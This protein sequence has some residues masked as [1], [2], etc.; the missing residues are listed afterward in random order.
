MTSELI[1]MN[2]NV[3]RILLIQDRIVNKLRCGDGS[4][5]VTDAV[6]SVLDNNQCQYVPEAV[7]TAERVPSL[8]TL[9]MFSNQ[10]TFLLKGTFS[11]V[12]TLASL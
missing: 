5:A 1:A 6:C 11:N 12:T 7:T 2:D 10:L 9:S 8:T 4:V 3:P